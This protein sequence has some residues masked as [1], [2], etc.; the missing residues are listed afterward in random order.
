MLL[1]DDG[2]CKYCVLEMKQKMDLSVPGRFPTWLPA[3]LLVVVIA[4]LGLGIWLVS[5]DKPNSALPAKKDPP[6]PMDAELRNRL[7]GRWHRPDGGYILT[8]TA[9]RE[10]GTVT[11]QYA[12]PRP[13]NVARA[14]LTTGGDRPLLY[15]EL[16]DGGYDGNHYRL[17]YNPARDQ[18][19]GTY[20]Q[21]TMNQS[22]DVFFERLP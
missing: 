10:D 15:V 17:A 2:D 4:G 12:N 6:A 20:Q 14:Q 16:R 7:V 11:A 5:R 18:L 8:I 13:I 3:L 9:V 1:S 21:V 22:F 19:V